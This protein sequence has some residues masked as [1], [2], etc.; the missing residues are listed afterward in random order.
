MSHFVAQEARELLGLVNTRRI[1]VNGC[2]QVPKRF[3]AKLVQ[4]LSTLVVSGLHGCGSL[5]PGQIDGVELLIDA[6]GA[7]PQ[8]LCWYTN[9]HKRNEQRF[10]WVAS[11]RVFR[12]PDP[13]TIPKIRTALSLLA[14]AKPAQPEVRV[15]VRG[16]I[17]HW[18]RGRIDV[19]G[20]FLHQHRHVVAGGTNGTTKSTAIDGYVPADTLAVEHGIRPQRLSEAGRQGKVKMKPAPKGHM[21]SAGKRIRTLY[22]EQQ[23]IKHCTPKKRKSR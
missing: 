16:I 5:K 18:H 22:H 1:L 11:S 17:R 15:Q 19:R 13:T 8:E 20:E 6:L 12:L 4:R 21:N 10:D 3:R 23:A 14:R 7:D 2:E 9:Q